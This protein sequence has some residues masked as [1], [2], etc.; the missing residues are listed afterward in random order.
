LR[1][2]NLIEE[3]DENEEEDECGNVHGDHLLKVTIG[4]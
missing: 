1:P 2:G 3:E 4:F